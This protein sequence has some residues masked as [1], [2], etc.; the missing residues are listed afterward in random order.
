[1]SELQEL[2]TEVSKLRKENIEIDIKFMNL[3]R[4]IEKI[5]FSQS[6]KE[7]V[8]MATSIIDQVSIDHNTALKPII[9]EKI[10]P[11]TKRVEKRRGPKPKDKK[12]HGG[13][14]LW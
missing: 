3:Y 6:H 1:M 12:R 10:T 14:S 11:Q 7:A 8:T 13:A 5:K 9:N 4:V 2:S